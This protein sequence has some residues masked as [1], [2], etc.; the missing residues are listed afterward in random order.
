[1]KRC[2]IRA[3]KVVNCSPARAMPKIYKENTHTSNTVYKWAT[4]PMDGFQKKKYR[5][6][7]MV[8]KYSVLSATNEMAV[9]REGI[10]VHET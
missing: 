1:M 4:D 9:K 8:H 6:L 10:N 3:E 2:H 7:I 5:L